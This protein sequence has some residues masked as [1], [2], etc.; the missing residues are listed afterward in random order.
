M[1]YRKSV[2]EYKIDQFFELTFFRNSLRRSIKTRIALFLPQI[3]NEV[4]PKYPN[5][6]NSYTINFLNKLQS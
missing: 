6:F 3:E 4:D 2:R 5:S 1:R